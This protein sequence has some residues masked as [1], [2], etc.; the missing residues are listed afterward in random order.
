MS[1]AEQLRP[2]PPGFLEVMMDGDFPSGV[3]GLVLTRAQARLAASA[4]SVHRGADVLYHGTRYAKQIVA[5]GALVSC[6]WGP[7]RVSLTRSPEVAAF[8]AWPPRDHQGRPAILVFDRLSL[9]A[10]PRGAP[11]RR[12]DRTWRTGKGRS[13]GVHPR[14]RP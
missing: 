8:S 2:V 13:R 1:R 3:R 5:E 9:H 4:R 10:I 7:G 14:G 12:L 6:E 11:S